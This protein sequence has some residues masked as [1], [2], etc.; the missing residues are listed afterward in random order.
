MILATPELGHESPSLRVVMHPLQLSPDIQPYIA[1]LAAALR[2]RG[3]VPTEYR[4]IDVIRHPP[5]VI[6][7]HWPEHTLNRSCLRR[8]V[9]GLLLLTTLWFARLRGAVLVLTAHNASPHDLALDRSDAWFL[10]SFDRLVDGVLVLSRSGW[11]DVVRERPGLANAVVTHTRHGDFSSA[12]PAP[13]PP[14]EARREIGIDPAK[15][16]VVFAGQ[17]RRYKGVADLL[18]AAR[19]L[20]LQVVVAGACDDAALRAGLERRAH[21]D[22][23][24]HLRLGH[25]SPSELSRIVAAGTAVVLPYRRVLNSGSA[26][27]ALSLSRPVILPD[28]PTFRELQTEVGR[29]WVRLFHGNRLTSSS[30]ET[31]LSDPPSGSPDLTDY[32]WGKVAEATIEGYRRTREMRCQGAPVER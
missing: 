18:D 7:L 5:D 19:E 31:A 29:Q 11:T 12:Y 8:R 9:R 14:E 10:R 24:L 4:T 13:P 16:T 1:L 2:Q 15:R 17:V 20:D 3:V 27:L 21:A 25:Q 32:D 22:H 6:H 23:R 30:L 26:V 28:T